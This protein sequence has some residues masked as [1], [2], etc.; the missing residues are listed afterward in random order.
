[1]GITRIKSDLSTP[2]VHQT[3]KGRDALFDRISTEYSAPIARLARAHEAD[4]SLQQDLIQ[5]IHIALWRSLPAFGARCSLRTWVYRVAYNIAAT[6]VQRQRRHA[7]KNL[8]GLDDIDIA[9]DARAVDTVVDEARMLARLYAL[10]QRLKPL[11]RELFV[12][13]LEG[14]SVEE[15][16]DIAGLSHANIHTKLHRIRTLLAMQLNGE[17]P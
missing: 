16:A 15:M 10:I 1:M 4:S 5:E 12:L 14:L 2:A 8:I 9:S 13:Y 6:H 11:D 17:S 3:D 7:G